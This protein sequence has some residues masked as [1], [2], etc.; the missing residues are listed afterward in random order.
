M[1]MDDERMEPTIINDQAK[2]FQNFTSPL[3]ITASNCREDTE[4]GVKIMRLLLD[5]PLINV[6]TKD[7]K[8]LTLLM[9]AIGKSD[10]MVKMLL[11]NQTTQLNVVSDKGH[12]AVSLACEEKSV[13]S[14]KMF[15]KD[16]RWT[17]ELLKFAE[18][19]SPLLI[20]AHNCA[21]DI[22]KILLDQPNID[23]NI[24]NTSGSTPLHLAACGNCPNIVEMLLARKD[25]EVD[26]LDRN[27]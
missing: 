17:P 4:N 21:S 20:I 27:S 6:N 13:E 8:G 24:Q 16:K 11:E 3:N 9:N 18:G 25:I 7:H 2:I 15:L 22:S 19:Y 26:I 12:S 14:L 1:L 23:V 5:Q 10:D